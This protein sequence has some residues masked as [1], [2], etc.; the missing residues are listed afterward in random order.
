MA[1]NKFLWGLCGGVIAGLLLTAA[2]VVSVSRAYAGRVLPG[3]SLGSIYVGGLTIP[4][5][6]ARFGENISRAVSERVRLT[7]NGELI[8]E[9]RFADLGVVVP[10]D[11]LV[12]EAMA[13]GRRGDA[14]TQVSE[15]TRG[16][17]GVSLPV[18]YQLQPEKFREYIRAVIAP[19][20]T[21][22]RDAGWTVSPAG[23]LTFVPAASGNTISET[24]LAQEIISRLLRNDRRE[25]AVRTRA[26]QPGISDAAARALR[27]TVERVSTTPV[28][29]T[30]GSDTREIPARALRPWI[31]VEMG[32]TGP[33]VIFKRAPL[34]HYLRDEVASAVDRPPQNAR[35]EFRDGRAQLFTP[36]EEGMALDARA[37]AD[38]IRASVEEGGA[39]V[40]LAVKRAKPEISTTA[41]LDR[42][43]VQTLLA[44]GESDFAG[45]PRNRMHNIRVG[46]A[47]YHGV[48]I[49]PGV[50]FSFN[51]QLGPV[52]AATGYKPEL[53]IRENVTTPEYGGGLCQVST[54]AFRAAILS[55]LKVTARKNHAYPVVYYGTPG[56]DA[57]IYPPSPDLKF[58]N[59]TPG[60]ILIQTRIEG[61]KLIFDFWGTSDG[62]EV[63][64]VGPTTYDRRANGALK[65]TLTQQVFR[66]GQMIREDTFV[67]SYK[68]P[69]LFP[70]VL[71]ANAERE[72]WEQRVQRIAE[73]DRKAREEF[74]RKQREA[75]R[76]RPTPA[77][78]P[79]VQEGG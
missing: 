63:S 60:H 36:P 50:E 72:S 26:A 19:H 54:T 2:F 15:W 34:E 47:R 51:E 65:A 12:S 39:A 43:G 8:D 3:V 31:T 71:A 22:P 59:D 46:A 76:A 17:S 27:G 58:V 69:K 33:R 37:S 23:A 10:R 74:E 25:I 57:T 78:R 18:Q 28:V 73:K 40:A 64:V 66:D 79:S 35:F 4:E 41:D 6:R 77:P 20:A 1:K 48:L 32:G 45:S 24:E 16:V 52:T 30:Y 11:A 55:G 61:T 53:V 44:R 42:L 68:S 7:L 62:R 56:F 29:L 9:P 70:H 49:S 13:F 14:L 38:A 5:A 75:A 67:S 21:P